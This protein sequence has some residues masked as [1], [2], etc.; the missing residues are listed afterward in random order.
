MAWGQQILGKILGG[1]LFL[2]RGSVPHYMPCCYL[3][4][5]NPIGQNFHIKII[6]PK[7]LLPL[8]HQGA[9]QKCQKLCFV[10]N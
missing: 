7:I 9:P 4:S 10:L 8:Y 6:T 2:L 3:I 5:L 1:L